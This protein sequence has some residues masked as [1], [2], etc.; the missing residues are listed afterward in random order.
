VAAIIKPFQAVRI[1]SS[2]S[3]RGRL[4]RALNK[5]TRAVINC[6]AITPGSSDS[7]RAISAIGR[8]V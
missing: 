4:L 3:G 8:A 1:L 6:R 7:P 2:R 5:V